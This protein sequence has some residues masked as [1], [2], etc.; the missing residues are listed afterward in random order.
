MRGLTVGL[1]GIAGLV[2]LLWLA[3]RLWDAA[4]LAGGTIALSGGTRALLAV[5]RLKAT[6][7]PVGLRGI[8]LLGIGLLG[9]GLRGIARLAVTLLGVPRLP[10]PRLPVARRCV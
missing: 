5:A 9:I 8:G 6:L 2:A 3:V 4:L 1:R 10:V 7:L